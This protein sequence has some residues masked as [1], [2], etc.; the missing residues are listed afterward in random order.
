MKEIV[1][2]TLGHLSYGLAGAMLLLFVSSLTYQVIEFWQAMDGI[3]IYFIM[4]GGFLMGLVARG[5]FN[6]GKR[7]TQQEQYDEARKRAGQ[8]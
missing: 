8:S 1:R 6:L 7:R 4:G 2:R 5:G 3:I